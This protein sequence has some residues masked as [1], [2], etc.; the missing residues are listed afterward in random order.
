MY[1]LSEERFRKEA[2][3]ALHQ[4][5]VH[6]DPWDEPFAPN[7]ETRRLLYPVSYIPE[8][9]LLDAIAFA[10]TETGEVGFYWSVIERP[11]CS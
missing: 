5:F 1:T 3:P 9:P 6:E 10:A 8:P 7:V 11:A 4:V 2:A